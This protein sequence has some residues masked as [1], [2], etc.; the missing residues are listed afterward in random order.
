MTAVLIP[1]TRSAPQRRLLHLDAAGCVLVGL[2]LALAAETAA[3]VLGT[4]SVATVR[5]TGLALLLGAV[6]LV[7]LSVR[8]PL[9][10]ALLAAGLTALTW[11]LG[12]LVVAAVADLGGAGRLLVVAQG[13]AFGLLGLFQ[14]RAARRGAP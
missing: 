12:S 7:T 8:A 1:P 13:L 3:D 10:P 11:E 9:R 6:L 4:S 14:L 2:P 5:A